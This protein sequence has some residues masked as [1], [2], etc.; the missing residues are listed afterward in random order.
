MQSGATE[1]ELCSSKVGF[2]ALVDSSAVDAK[3]S[4]CG[5]SKLIAD[6]KVPS[7]AKSGAS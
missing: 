4:G 7:N 1:F 3:S 2:P 6:F 5:V